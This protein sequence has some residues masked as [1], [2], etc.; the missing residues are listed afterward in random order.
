MET[1]GNY[2]IKHFHHSQEDKYSL[3][4]GSYI[5]YSYIKKKTPVQTGL[6]I[7]SETV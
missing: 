5:L 1:A 7:S 6:E 2:H 4:C 3:I